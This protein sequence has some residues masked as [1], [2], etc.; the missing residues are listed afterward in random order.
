MLRNIINFTRVIAASLDIV[1]LGL[2][3]NTLVNMLAFVRANVSVGNDKV[4]VNGFLQ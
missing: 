3:L 2:L 4:F 1:F